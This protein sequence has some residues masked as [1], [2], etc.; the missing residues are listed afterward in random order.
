MEQINFERIKNIHFIGIGGVSMSALAQLMLK[1]KKNI[2]GSD[3]QKG[4]LVNLLLKKKMPIEIGEEIAAKD[5]VDLV[6]YTDAISETNKEFCGY[7]QKNIPCISRGDFLEQV[8][9]LFDKVVAVSGSHGKTTTTAMIAHILL[10]KQRATMH[11]GGED[12]TYGNFVGKGNEFFVTEACEYKK[13]VEKI[14]SHTSV[15]T[16]VELDHTDCYKNI[17][18]ITETFECFVAKSSHN[19][20]LYD[21]VKISIKNKYINVIKVGFKTDSDVFCF[22]VRELK[23][24]YSFHIKNGNQ[25][26]GKFIL[27]VDGF[28]NLKNALCAIATC[29]QLDVP[30]VE[31]YDGLKSFVG[32][33]RRNERLGKLYEKPV[34][35]DYAHHPTEISSSIESMNKKY[36]KVLCVFQPH[37]YSRTVGLMKEFSKCFE[38]TNRLIIFKTYPAREVEDVRGNE[39]ALY[40][41]IV[42]VK[43]KFLTID[44]KRLYKNL[45]EQIKF[46]DVVLVLGAGDIYEIMKK[47]VK[48][49]KSL[50]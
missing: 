44:K 30:Y 26:V 49:K 1:L 12:I 19:V 15:I 3:R 40:K 8:C 2:S 42:G 24:G 6:I 41:N 34:I 31:I 23:T 46:C 20:I 16:S 18:E 14:A 50:D 17:R 33:K 32:V 27:N 45:R 29:L 37:T 47:Y 35:A 22:G 11:L 10:Q 25:Y 48:H 38:K 7:K 13:N 28:Y 5:N 43:R 36:G 21:D 4:P 9:H 39:T